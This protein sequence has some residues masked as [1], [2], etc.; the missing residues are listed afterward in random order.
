SPGVLAI[1]VTLDGYEQKSV[2][3]DATA[4]QVATVNIVLTATASASAS[5]AASDP[6]AALPSITDSGS[7]Q[8]VQSAVGAGSGSGGGFS[9]ILILMGVV[10]VLLGVGGIALILWRRKKDGQEPEGDMEDGGPHGPGPVPNSRGSYR[11][12]PADGT[13][14]MRGGGYDDRT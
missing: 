4:G 3:K 7:V 9:K 6:G 1:N 2:P 14:M 13:A 10:L 12:A 5:A 8:P 11:G